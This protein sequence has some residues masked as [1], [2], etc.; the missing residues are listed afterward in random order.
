LRYRFTR[1]LENHVFS[2]ASRV[3]TICNG[4][5]QDIESRQLAR[6]PITVVPN[7]VDYQR[8]SKEVPRDETLATQLGLTAGRT[9][10]FVG[11][12]YDYEGLDQAIAAMP[13]LLQRDPAFRL[14]LVGGGMQDEA[15]RAQAQSLG[16]GKQVIF[17]GKVPFSDV[18][19]Y[20]SVID[21]LV[22]PRKSLR[23]T[24]TVT[25]LK[26]LEAMALRKVFVASDVGGHH[27]LVRHRDTGILF[28]A[29]DVSALVAAVSDLLNDTALQ[30]TLQHNGLAHVRDERNWRNSVARYAE[31]YAGALK[32][33]A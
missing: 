28:K 10:G 12:F 27:E 20:Y 32:A 31:V 26:P 1:A 8:F 33:Q 14:V 9:L 18:E 6:A 19:R 2:R 11:S 23:L 5:R 25:P 13:A 21:A 7:A 22:Y 30:S 16:L 24:E 15:L 17:T 3:V 29:D 4:L